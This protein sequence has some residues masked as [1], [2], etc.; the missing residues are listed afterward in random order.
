MGQKRLEHARR[1]HDQIMNTGAKILATCCQNCLSQL[2]DLRDRY[3]MPVQVKSV[4]ELLVES[5]DSSSSE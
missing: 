3:D 2:T 1:K 4:I 5:M